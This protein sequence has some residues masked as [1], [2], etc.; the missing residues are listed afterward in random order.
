MSANYFCDFLLFRNVTNAAEVRQACVDGKFRSDPA[1][2][3]DGF[4]HGC[5]AILKSSLVLDPM[6]L[7]VAVSKAVLVRTSILQR[8]GNRRD[9]IKLWFIIPFIIPVQRT[10]ERV[11]ADKGLQFK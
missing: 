11:K 1:K 7:K 6:Q 8:F 3:G 9:H 10:I 4:L 2:D 5:V